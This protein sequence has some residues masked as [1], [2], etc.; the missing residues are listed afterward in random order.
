MEFHLDQV[1]WWARTA[2][3]QAEKSIAIMLFVAA[4][5]RMHFSLSTLAAGEQETETVRQPIELPSRFSAGR[6]SP[7]ELSSFQQNIEIISRNT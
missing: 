7:F 6:S 2:F 4:N 5:R 1:N 3:D